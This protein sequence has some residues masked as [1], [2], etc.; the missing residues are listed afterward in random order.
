MQTGN[1]ETIRLHY[2]VLHAFG[3]SIVAG[4]ARFPMLV[5]SYWHSVAS[6][7]PYPKDPCTYIGS[8][9][10]YSIYLGPKGTPLLG[11]SMI[12][13][14]EVFFSL[15]PRCAHTSVQCLLLRLL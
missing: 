15:G 8:M 13:D 12:L 5:P 3:K 6:L 4:E 1:S 14:R 7:K 11:P 10:L 2:G 9:Y